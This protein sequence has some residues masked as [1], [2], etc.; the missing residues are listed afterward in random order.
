MDQPA[1]IAVDS[2][3]NV[4]VTGKSQAPKAGDLTG[5]LK[6]YDCVT[7]KYNS[8][9]TQQWVR[10]YGSGINADEGAAITVDGSGYVY[11][12]GGTYDPS[13]SW[14][15]V[16]IKYSADGTQQW[17]RQYGGAENQRDSATALA[18]DTG[19][20]VYVTGYRYASVS[21]GYYTTL[22]YD[23]AGTQQWVSPPSSAYP[24]G[25]G[26]DAAFIALSPGG[27]SVLV[28]GSVDRGAGADADF[29][30]MKYNTADGGQAWAQYYDGPYS[31]DDTVVGLA[32]DSAGNA[33]V[34]GSITIG[35]TM[36]MDDLDFGVV[37]YNGGGSQVW[38]QSY[39]VTGSQADKAV[40]LA[41]DA[42]GNVYV[43]GNVWTAGWTYQWATVKFDAD[44]G[45]L[46][47]TVDYTGLDASDDVA[48]AIVVSPAGG[49]YVTGGSSGDFAT[50]KYVEGLTG[51]AVW[52]ADI[53]VTLSGS[54]TRDINTVVAIPTELAGIT[55][56]LY[57][58]AK[59][60]N[61]G[62]QIVAESAPDAF[63]ITA[64]GLSLTMGRTPYKEFHRPGETIT[65]SGV[66]ENNGTQGPRTAP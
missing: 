57:L 56:K 1:A 18:L 21:V 8:A 19:G 55:G 24:I 41:L 42:D 46:E 49:L 25:A 65:I 66:V 5:T 63:Y 23:S 34:A 13:T 62:S 20:N 32:V 22:K 26:Q 31:D 16:T 14:D 61:S 35:V 43:A 53:P 33:V 51:D 47:W 58:G 10:S 44:S 30:L 11:V 59:L 39:G 60:L 54:E 9:G 7:I 29:A 48:A 36:E 3:G 27:A 4:Y 38:D 28:A 37:K 17:A 15:Y 45:E 64:S 50:V 2:S 12:A 6:Q 40:G 52:E